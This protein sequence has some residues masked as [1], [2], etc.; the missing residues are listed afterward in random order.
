MSNIT[1]RTLIIIWLCVTTLLCN[2]ALDY[3]FYQGIARTKGCFSESVYKLHDQYLRE[4]PRVAKLV[5]KR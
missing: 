3:G 5:Q 1:A 2:L 4:N